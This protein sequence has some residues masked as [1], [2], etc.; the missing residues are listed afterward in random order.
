MHGLQQRGFP[1]ELILALRNSSFI[2]HLKSSP[3]RAF[4]KVPRNRSLL[5]HLSI[6]CWLMPTAHHTLIK[7]HSTKGE[8]GQQRPYRAHV[9]GAE[10]DTIKKR[11]SFPSHRFFL[12]QMNYFV[13]VPF[14]V[15]HNSKPEQLPCL[16]QCYS[17]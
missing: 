9:T 8:A 15:K 16:T 1:L 13:V 5:I 14:S 12:L 10:T 2:I 6:H 3:I 17:K 11:P 4:S 7:A